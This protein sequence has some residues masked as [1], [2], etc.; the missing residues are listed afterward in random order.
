MIKLILVRHGQS[1]WNAENRFT[2]WVD[3]DLS[4]KGKKEA[5]K[6]GE[7]IRELNINIDISYTSYLKRAIE[8]LTIILKTLN[9]SMKF[10]TS[11]KINERNYGSLTGLN[12]EETKKKLGEEQFKRYR[13]SWDVAPPPMAED[14]QYFE[15]FGPLNSGIQKNKIPLT[16]SLKNTYERVVPFYDLEIKKNLKNG[17]NI[18]ISAHGNSLRAL[19]KYLF[20]ISD[21]KINELEIPTG[22]PLIIEFDNQL[23]I[24]KYY[25]LDK[26]RAKNIIFNQ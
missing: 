9:L 17:K 20:K 5:K 3:V 11:W 14:S 10:N 23:K 2:G 25:Y 18:L 24:K 13:R 15:N 7:L 4:E 12:K 22:N 6:S 1:I 16:E 19:C 26:S 8:T 21:T